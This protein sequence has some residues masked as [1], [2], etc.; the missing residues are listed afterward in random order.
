MSNLIEKFREAHK[1]VPLNKLVD[2]YFDLLTKIE[3]CRRK[4]DFRKM[5]MHCQ[6]SLSLLEPLI[7]QTKKEFGTFD[8]S[9]ISA[10]EVGSIFWAIYGAE[11]QLLNIKEVVEY[12]PELEPWKE[13]IKKAFTIK[14]L[15]QKIYQ[16]VTDNKGCLQK[17]LKKALG[18]EDGKLTSN[19]VYYMELVG[20]LERKKVKNTYSLFAERSTITNEYDTTS[21]NSG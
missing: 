16:Y 5:L 8:I 10:I 7:E 6:M 2:A 4:K 15:A 11:G 18:V 1:G 3:E 17:E 9:G 14:E 19:V 20:K 12:F 21:S 13:T